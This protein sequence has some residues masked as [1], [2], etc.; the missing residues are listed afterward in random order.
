[1]C[2]G[3]ERVETGQVELKSRAWQQEIALNEVGRRVL[4]K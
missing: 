1:M 4:G 3:R 2:S